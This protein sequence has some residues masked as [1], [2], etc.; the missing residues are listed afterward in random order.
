MELE[1]YL[2]EQGVW[3]RFVEK[4]E[5]VHTADA[6]DATGIEL[7]RI[8]K[9]LV[10]KTRK[11]G[12]A[13]IVVPGDKRVDLKAAARALGVKNVRLLPFAEAEEISGYPPGGT[14]SVGHKTE[15]RVVLDSKLLEMET[16]YCGG[17]TRDRL[18]ELRV[19]D[20]VR[21]NDAVVAPISRSD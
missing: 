5:T 4:A 8:T 9:N 11:G 10:S 16:L 12:Y 14:P 15:M 19:E 20:I 6:S 21:L 3:Y 7:H 17:G 1:E 13:L 2:R 18:L